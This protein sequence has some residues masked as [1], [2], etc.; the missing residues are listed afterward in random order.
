MSEWKSSG[1]TTEKHW[2]ID[3]SVRQLLR[4]GCTTGWREST[5]VDI[6]KEKGRSF[7]EIFED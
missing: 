7:P 6:S 3:A 5:G 2:N 1:V 4:A